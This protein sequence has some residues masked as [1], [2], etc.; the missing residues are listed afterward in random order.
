MDEVFLVVFDQKVKVTSK[1][2]R[3]PSFSCLKMVLSIFWPKNCE[4]MPF[5]QPFL[6][7]AQSFQNLNFR[8]SKSTVEILSRAKIRKKGFFHIFEKLHAKIW[9]KCGFKQ[10]E[11]SIMVDFG[12]AKFFSRKWKSKILISTNTVQNFRP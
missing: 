6:K 7:K 1:I 12:V 4:K 3:K 8:F 11:K 10:V 9:L 2:G 5:W